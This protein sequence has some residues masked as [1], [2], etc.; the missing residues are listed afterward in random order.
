MIRKFNNLKLKYKI[1][2]STTALTLFL[3]LSIAVI[4]MVQFASLYKSDAQESAMQW[5]DIARST[6]DLEINKIQ[7]GIRGIMSRTFL[8]QTFSKL[9]ENGETEYSNYLDAKI[10]LQD[11]IDEL[12]A[13]SPMI[14]EAY[15]VDRG[16]N[17]Y[18]KYDTTIK[19]YVSDLFDFKSMYSCNGITF[20]KAHPS[21]F[22]LKK[23]VI[24]MI[25]PLKMI[26]TP[27]YLSIANGDAEILLIMLLDYNILSQELNKGDSSYFKSHCYLNLDGNPVY[28]GDAAYSGNQL[29]FT[30]TVDTMQPGM[31]MTIAVQKSTYITKR[32]NLLFLPILLSLAVLAAGIALLLYISNFL[33]RPFGLMMKIIDQIKHNTYNLAVKPKYNDEIGVL[34]NALNSMYVTINEQIDFIRKTEKEKTLYLEQM[35]TEQIN[36]HFIYNTLEAINMEV[37]NNHTDNASVM[38]QDFANILRYT[39]NKGLD[40]TT[41]ANEIAHAEAYIRI[42]NR[43]LNTKIVY[44]S[45]FSPS[46]AGFKIPKVMVQPMIEN[47]IKHGFDNCMPN[48]AI[49]M[50]PSISVSINTFGDD[51]ISICVTDN[52]KGIDK[53]KVLE[54]I[55]SP[56]KSGHIGLQNIYNRLKLYFE[57]VDIN[58]ESIPYYK[59]TIQFVIS[60]KATG[61]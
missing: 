45:E 61:G 9:F 22:D 2:I 38:I 60:M 49:M 8:Q 29:Y 5:L 57:T 21:P 56:E 20:Q 1:I 48:N 51:R 52:G 35:L 10:A 54:I 19:D 26:G 13:L 6:F 53:E 41:V 4:S 3:C 32:N 17:I 59:N 31:S 39:L 12:A 33:T 18:T 34:I 50:Q 55:S 11:D 23:T 7:S 40:M 42:I 28:S 24:P 44:K 25:I 46:I 37:L 30:N 27:Q 15:F 16:N 58:I 14:S 43:R 36:P 47:A